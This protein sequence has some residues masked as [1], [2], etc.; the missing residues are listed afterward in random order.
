MTCAP[1]AITHL[2]GA[3]RCD[4][5]FRRIVDPRSDGMRRDATGQPGGGTD[6]EVA[7]VCVGVDVG[8]ISNPVSFVANRTVS[9]KIWRLGAALTTERY[10]CALSVPSEPDS[11]I[12]ITRSQPIREEADGGGRGGCD[13]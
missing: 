2:D 3:G 13:G 1:T 6:C 8:R 4:V 9:G 12:Q 11:G 5:A 7:G 10:G